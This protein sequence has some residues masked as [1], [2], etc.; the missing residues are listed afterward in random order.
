MLAIRFE[1]R[2]WLDGARAEKHPQFYP[3]AMRICF[4]FSIRTRA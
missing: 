4:V 1:A 2:G 3:Q